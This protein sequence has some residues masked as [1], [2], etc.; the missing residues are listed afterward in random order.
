MLNLSV[1]SQV[2]ADGKSAIRTHKGARGHA[3]YGPYVQVEPGRYIVEFSIAFAEHVVADQDSACAVVDVVGENGQ[4]DIA[5]DFV[6]LSDLGTDFRTVTLAFDLE[7]GRPLEFRV[8][9]TGRF[10]LVVQDEPVLRLR[11]P[12][13]PDQAP[14][15]DRN[16]YALRE[17]FERDV[18]FSISHDQVSMQISRG[19]VGDLFGLANTSP[20]DVARQIAERVGFKGD[21]HNALYRAYIGTD[22]PIVSPPREVPFTS[23]LCQQAHFGYDQYRFWS[24]ALK[25]KPKFYRK[26][27]EFVFI[28]QALFERGFLASGK[29]GLVFGAGQEPLPALFASFGVEVLATDQGAE[30]AE[31]TGW[32]ATHQHTFDLSALNQLGICTDRMFRNLVSFMPVDMNAIPESLDRQF[33]FCWSACALEHLGSLEHG[34]AFIENSMRTLRPGGIAVHTTEFNLSSNEDTLESPNCS[35]YRRRDIEDVIARLERRGY[36]VSP[37]DWSVGEGFAERVVDLPPFGRGE[38]HIRLRADRYDVTSIG[39]IIQA[40]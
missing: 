10:P 6:M 4:R 24:R 15:R 3:I 29:K 37:L 28:A 27:W 12:G 19:Q 39:L 16:N 7:E 13:D 18:P 2:G 36:Q 22:H 33:D 21:D 34:L 11:R 31:R 23:T 32:A 8:Y 5:F 38:P 17:L 26:Q 40:P 14:A 35:F 1:G 30:D 20:D 9:T 25:D